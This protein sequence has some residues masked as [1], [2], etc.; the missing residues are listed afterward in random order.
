MTRRPAPAEPSAVL[1]IPGRHVERRVAT[2]GLAFV[3]VVV[4]ASAVVRLAQAAAAAVAHVADRMMPDTWPTVDAGPALTVLPWLL[5][6]VSGAVCAL[7]V[8][9][10]HSRSIRKGHTARIRGLLKVAAV[11]L[12]VLAVVVTR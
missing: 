4:V 9:L 8:A 2:G 5:I 10:A 12:I 11:C 6:P 1:P 7:Y 3:A